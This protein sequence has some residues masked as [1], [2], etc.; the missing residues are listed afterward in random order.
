[1]GL[2]L[3]FY[4][5]TAPVNSKLSGRQSLKEEGSAM[6]FGLKNQRQNSL[7]SIERIDTKGY[8]SE[9]YCNGIIGAPCTFLCKYNCK[10]FRLIGHDHDIGGEGG[11]GI[12]EGQFET[13]KKGKYKRILIQRIL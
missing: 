1:M 9:R 12:C 10:Q 6:D 11:A 8:L 5:N 2:Q 13:A 3:P 4:V 7:L